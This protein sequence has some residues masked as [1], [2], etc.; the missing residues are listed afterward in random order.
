MRPLS[1]LFASR[2]AALFVL[3]AGHVWHLPGWPAA[4]ALGWLGVGDLFF[5]WT[6]REKE[7]ED[8]L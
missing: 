6:H 8:D 3:A 2:A 4:V 1:R 7:A 5:S